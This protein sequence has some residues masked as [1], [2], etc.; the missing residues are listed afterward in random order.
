M[1][2][3][4][5]P[6]TSEELPLIALKDV[7]LFPKIVTPLIVQRPKSIAGLEVG[8]A[9]NGRVVF[10]SQ[11]NLKDDADSK[12]LFKVGTV[13]RIVSTNRLTDGSFKIDV[14]G[15]FR[16]KISNVSQEEPFFLARTE[17]LSLEYQPSIESE[18]LIR[19]VAEQF[20]KV[21]ESK[22]FAP[23]MPSFLLTLGQ[24]K[25]PEQLISIISVNLNLDLLDQQQILETLNINEALR[26]VS[27]LLTR[28]I[29]IIEAER[30]VA[31]ETKKQLGRMQKE[32]FL[33]EQMKSI[34]K[35][36][37]VDGEK[38]EYEQLRTKIKKSGM[39]KDVEK[40]ASKE[41]SRLEKMPMFSP[42]VSYLRTYLDW[43]VELPWSV[44]TKKSID[45]K[46]AEKVL[47][48]DHY[49]L[50]KAKERIL[51]YLAVQKQVGKV[52]GPILCFIGPPGTGKTSIGR[53]IAGALGRKFIRVSLGGL[54]DEAELRGHRRTYVGALPGRIIQGIHT[55]GA[56]DP[57]FMLDE[58]DKIGQDFRGDPAAALLEALDPE[59]NFSFSDNYL[60]VPF[61]LS[62]V[63]F[64]TTAN[65]LDTVPP[66]LRDRL[67]VIEFP[68]YTEDEKLNIAKNFLVPKLFGQHGLKEKMFSMGDGAITDVIRKHTNEAGVR[69][70]ERKLSTVIAGYKRNFLKTHQSEG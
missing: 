52:K 33:R 44:C 21:T 59:Q 13:G 70:L 62:D 10:V 63:I 2:K 28:E 58:I 60:E 14:D 29:E 15:L 66:A 46:Q 34:E 17:P 27:L 65:R 39:S 50:D 56:K 26:K 48:K 22:I 43:L 11:R 25:D 12:D 68:G 38:G 36:L 23:I 19:S 69:E 47:N 54:H 42:E 7:A 61:D 31:R 6:N 57:V 64:I 49:A 55:V 53:S 40:K 1:V 8:L 20:K 67:E 18:A 30:K 24:I 16:A 5:Y 45:L 41:L 3:T 4:N 35:E 37:G 51:E 32:I 9:K